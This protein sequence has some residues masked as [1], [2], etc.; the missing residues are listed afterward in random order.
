MNQIHA[1]L[2]TAPDEVR[3]DYRTLTGR[4]LV[5]TLARSR[6]AG[7]ASPALTARQTLKRLARRHVMLAEEIE[8]IDAQ[9]EEFV[10]A[11][12]PTLLSLRGVGVVTAATLLVAAG[13]NPERL[14]EQGR[15]RG[16]LSR[17]AP[18]P[19]LVRTADPPPALTRRQPAREQRPA[20]DR[21]VAHSTSRT[22]NDGLL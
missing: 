20:P 5:N 3:S 19:R 22:T 1:L 4:T 16:A 12:N 13:D 6:P 17:V 10:R 15:V 7:G 9:L 18:I 21:A 11:I 8:V 2:I 14:A